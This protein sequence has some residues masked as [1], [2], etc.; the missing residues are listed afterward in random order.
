M[1]DQGPSGTF[2]SGGG[3]VQRR[4]DTV[5]P[6]RRSSGGIVATGQVAGVAA[7]QARSKLRR[8]TPPSPLH[9]PS[10]YLAAALAALP[11]KPNRSAPGR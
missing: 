10:R 1:A 4:N 9:P 7:R 11:A 8:L 6:T 2:G 5:R 3:N